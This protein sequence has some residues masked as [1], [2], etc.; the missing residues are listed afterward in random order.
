METYGKGKSYTRV[1]PVKK[2]LQLQ[3]FIEKFKQQ[4]KEY[5]RHIVISWF[6]SNT[7]TEIQKPSRL[8]ETILF[9][10]SDFAENVVVIRKY[11]LAE[12]YFH[13]IEILLFGAVVSYV[14]PRGENQKSKIHH[15]SYMVSWDYR[16]VNL[17]AKY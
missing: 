12:Q 8:R 13:R 11:E 6:L 17:I 14:I 5:S 15:R 7:K 2:E 1:E 9:V 4:F 16:Y 3:E 10:T